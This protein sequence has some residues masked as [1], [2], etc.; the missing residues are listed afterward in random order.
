M[1]GAIVTGHTLSAHFFL[2]SLRILSLSDHKVDR[3]MA[4]R[5]SLDQDPHASSAAEDDIRVT[6]PNGDLA[7][8][9]TLPP[10]GVSDQ[11]SDAPTSGRRWRVRRPDYLTAGGRDLRLDLIRGFMV[12][13]MIVDHVAGSSPLEI[14]TG[15]NRFLTSAAEGFVFISGLM[16]GLI[17]GRVVERRGM[18]AGLRKTLLRVAALYALTVTLTLLFIVFSERTGMP[19]AKQID[20]GSPAAFLIDVFT[21]QRTY[22]LVDVPLLYT[23]L[24]VCAP[25][26]LALLHHGKGWLVLTISISLYALYQV[27]PGRLILPWPIDGNGPFNFGAWQALFFVGMWLG[28]KQ[29]RLPALGA[30]ASR[31]V[32]LASGAAMVILTGVFAWLH[33]GSEQAPGGSTADA[34]A[35]Q[36]ARLWVQDILL[37]KGDLRPGRVFA[38]AVVLIFFF[39]LTTRHWGILKRILGPVLLPLGQNALYAYTVFVL[40]IGPFALVVPLLD[41][42]IRNGPWLTTVLKILAVGLI[43]LL[44]RLRFLM[45]TP[46]TR[47]LWFAAPAVAGVLVFGLLSQ[48]AAV[49][50][51]S[52]SKA[53][54]AYAQ[55]AQMV[56]ADLRPGDR[57]WLNGAESAD[58]YAAYD[59]N[60]ARVFALP[61]LPASDA[62]VDAALA[63]ATAGASRIHILFYGER[64][65]DPA[66]RYE[67]WLA[68]RA[69]KAREQWVG[70]VRFATYALR[71]A[72]A[73]A[74][75]GAAWRNGI[76]L[77]SAG[78]DLTDVS[79]GDI[80]P[81]ALS[82]TASSAP[83]TNYSVFVHLGL[84]DG[85]PLAQNDAAPASGFRPTASWRRG[86]I[87]L[88]QRGVLIP[89]G[90]PPGRYTLFVGLYDPTTGERLK[91]IS[92]ADRFGLGQVTVR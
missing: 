26:A 44:T 20:L 59:P 13:A 43:V 54:D 42:S 11:S 82:W 16:T 85:P 22:F 21:F 67:R 89:P 7:E 1:D 57:V 51:A 70:D 84:A 3:F 52:L 56:A 8:G 31:L 55:I 68:G 33:L 62:D 15:G 76:S 69:F 75:A 48:Q 53:R 46:R 36:S 40:L 73:P 25:A 39:F 24:F 72:L 58:A 83:T 66:S 61:E 9:F 5:D 14:L 81:L 35:A 45:P 50:N 63:R 79:A 17:Y 65:T 74:A 28:F 18:A 88:D 4:A 91:L 10:G 41:P 19:W 49:V 47:R 60:P 27:F 34:A 78:A 29:P 71:G 6:S 12:F 90:I 64:V 80:I 87:I 23:L 37:E 2:V 92:G 38:T 86:E 77:S 32:L 30:R